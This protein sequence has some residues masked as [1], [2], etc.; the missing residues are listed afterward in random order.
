MSCV[1][2]CESWNKNRKLIIKR[3]LF[4]TDLDAEVYMLIQA[5]RKILKVRGNT[6]NDSVTQL[7]EAKLPSNRKLKV[8]HIIHWCFHDERED[9]SIFSHSFSPSRSCISFK[10]IFHF[11]K[12]SDVC[13]NMYIKCSTTFFLYPSHT[14]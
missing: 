13:S 3:I 7:C 6:S 11:P 9:V 8:V 10:W 1:A 5:E 2:K 4:N 14:K 12:M